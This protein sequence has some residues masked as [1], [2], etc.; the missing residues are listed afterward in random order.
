VLGSRQVRDGPEHRGGRRNDA[1][2]FRCR[3]ALQVL[4]GR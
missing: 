3:R 2:R 4:Q 1:A